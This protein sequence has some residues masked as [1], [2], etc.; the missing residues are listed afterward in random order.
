M[1]SSNKTLFID[2]RTLAFDRFSRALDFHASQGYASSQDALDSQVLLFRF[3]Y[4]S[5]GQ[6]LPRQIFTNPNVLVAL[7]KNDLAYRF[8]QCKPLNLRSDFGTIICLDERRMVPFVL[9]K[10]S[11]KILYYDP[12]LESSVSS[13]ASIVSVKYASELLSSSQDVGIQVFSQIAWS[14]KSLPDILGF[15]FHG[16]PTEL[17]S[18]FVTTLAISIIQLLLPLFTS[19]IFGVVVPQA[20]LKFFAAI[21]LVSI[22]LVVSMS[23]AFFLRA[24]LLAQLESLIDFRLQAALVNR[25]LRQPLN[26]I[27]GFSVP[28]FVLRI[29]GFSSIRKNITNTVLISLFGLVF[30]GLNLILMYVYQYQ[31]SGYITIV[32]VSIALVVSVIVKQQRLLSD[33][34][35]Q[36]ETE[37]FDDT[38]LLIDAVPQLRSSATEYFFLSKWADKLRYQSEVNSSRQYLSDSVQI[39]S[40]S[41]YQISMVLVLFV[42]AYDFYQYSYKDDFTSLT[43]LF[44]PDFSSAGSFLAFIVAF[45]SFDTY[46]SSFIDT[47]TSNI[48]DSISQWRRSSP[49]LYQSPE[50]GYRPELV[51]HSPS[52]NIRF[53]NICYS[54]DDRQILENITL[55][56]LAGQ[57]VGITGP[58]GSGKST[59][60]RLIS[61]VILPNSGKV[62]ID[63]LPLQDLNLKSLRSS[64][65]VVTQVSIIPS[66]SIK[67]FLAPS[68][69][70]SDDEVWDAL[71]I[72]CIADEIMQMPM[73]LQTILSEGATNISGGQ[74]QRLLIAKALIKKP[75]ILLLDEATSALP[76]DT[77]SQIITNIQ[78]LNVT[79][80]SIAHR[81]DTIK[82]CEQIH[83][84]TNGR[85]V[86]SG[87]FENLK[88]LRHA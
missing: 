8:I 3:I 33:T 15:I 82:S 27:Q 36:S 14:L 19:A 40:R 7:D 69:S 67:E 43:G 25:V 46:F 60:I 22:P 80:L 58:S 28:D 18:V 53:E 34:I 6:A 83:Y 75:R 9:H 66:T 87:T 65:G 51:S 49:L 13:D 23:V 86:E 35:L 56:I 62:L 78:R 50:L 68:F 12:D 70:Y 42:V 16:R 54:I 63:D 73:R 64:I 59:F 39:L 29:Q 37:V 32:Y 41:S 84:F 81:L 21:L 61:G 2:S 88:S 10:Q 4:T 26:F 48:I 71:S 11:D 74:R 76:E 45:T 77:Q 57:Q 38:A 79:S 20:D 1:N 85:I 44:P 17:F 30:G 5:L 55:S 47:I 72:A 52:G 31:L 24:R